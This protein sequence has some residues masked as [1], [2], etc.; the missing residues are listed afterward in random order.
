MARKF[1]SD[2]LLAGRYIL[3]QV[4][5]KSEGRGSWIINEDAGKSQ[6]LSF[7]DIVKFSSIGCR[8]TEQMFPNCNFI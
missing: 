3:F 8:I 4:I 2:I 5:I 6:L 7:S 1:Y